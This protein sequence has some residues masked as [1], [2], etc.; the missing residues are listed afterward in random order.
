M[1]VRPASTSSRLGMGSRTNLVNSV[2]AIFWVTIRPWAP[3]QRAITQKII[4]VNS[5]A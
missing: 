1:S 3:N 5:E 4:E 2:V